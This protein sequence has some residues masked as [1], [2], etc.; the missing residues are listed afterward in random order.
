MLL[1]TL[2][3]LGKKQERR[4]C[5]RDLD[6]SAHNLSICWQVFQIEWEFLSKLTWACFYWL[7]LWADV[8]L[9]I[10]DN[11]WYK[12]FLSIIL[13]PKSEIMITVLNLLSVKLQSCEG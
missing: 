6:I 10:C 9:L 2:S 5:F 1:T 4:R 13:Y 3:P 12:D 8:E 7:A 11:L